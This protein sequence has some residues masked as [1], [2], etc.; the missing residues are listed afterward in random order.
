MR[1]GWLLVVGACGSSGPVAFSAGSGSG[2]GATASATELRPP[3]AL[4]TTQP[5]ATK[6]PATTPSPSTPAEPS[7]TDVVQLGLGW[8]HSCA[9]HHD[10]A[11]SCW[12]ANKHPQFDVGDDRVRSVPIAAR[13]ASDAIQIAASGYRTCVLDRAGA[14]SCWRG[15]DGSAARA[16]SEL[17]S[18]LVPP[19]AQI[20]GPCFR[21]RAGG[22]MCWNEHDELVTV[23]GIA[24][25]RDVAAWGGTGCAIVGAGN[26]ACWDHRNFGPAS[27]VP[28]A[29]PVRGITNAVQIAAGGGLA[30]AVLRNRRVTCWSGKFE[31]HPRMPRSPQEMLAH[32]DPIIVRPVAG[33]ADATGVIVTTTDACAL[34][35]S[36]AVA[37]WN[38]DLATVRP[39]ARAMATLIGVTAL[40]GAGHHAC[41]L[42]GARE[43]ACWGTNL[44]GELGN[45]WSTSRSIPIDVPG[46]TDVV[47]LSA[48]FRDSYCALRRSGR[49]TCWGGPPQAM[50][51]PDPRRAASFAPEV[52]LEVAG[53]PAIVDAAGDP[54]DA[55]GAVWARTEGGYARKAVPAS[56]TA[57]QYCAIARGGQLWCWRFA[58][59]GAERVPPV[60][61]TPA[62]VQAIP[63]AVAVA[64]GA[65]RSCALRATGNISCLFGDDRLAAEPID[66]R[67]ITDAIR[68]AVGQ[69]YLVSDDCAVRKDR[70]VWC[71]RW[72]APSDRQPRDMALARAPAAVGVD[73][74]VAI[75]VGSDAACAV[76]ATGGVACWGNNDRGQ[77]GDGEVRGHTRPAPVRDL[78]DAVAIVVGNKHAC[79]LRRT[80]HVACWGDTSGGAVGTFTTTWIATPVAVVWP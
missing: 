54:V 9:L 77:L 11:V 7:R 35:A 58:R 60:D 23:P 10:G 39:V 13:P 69:S 50:H 76:R 70:S 68:L 16:A 45:G 33:I 80:G 14:V 40:A 79:A 62:A 28:A 73:D 67:G 36:G 59:P 22:V 53:L 6:R 75:G 49:L 61:L 21:T 64:D 51:S 57:S 31:G 26:V 71:W 1:L 12:G 41:A 42:L 56:S 5:P 32:P 18:L 24:A 20:Q 44:W 3:D 17:T 46:M 19:I 2:S 47:A 72:S 8:W 38:R 27:K 29:V 55:R 15:L 63:D 48:G 65:N 34:R 52:P 25:A 78:R 74:A 66:V 30:C 4:G 43:I 37:C